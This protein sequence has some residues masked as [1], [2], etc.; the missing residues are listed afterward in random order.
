MRYAIVLSLSC[1]CTSGPSPFSRVTPQV[2]IEA[3]PGGLADE[4]Y[5]TVTLT[6]WN[7]L[8]VLGDAVAAGE[9][10]ATL[11]DAPLAL[12]PGTTGYVGGHDAYTVTFAL[13]APR[14]ASTA[15][16]AASSRIAIS[17]GEITWAAAVPNLFANDLAATAPLAAGSNTFVW[18]S[19]AATGP[20][21]TIEWACVAVGDQAS[22]CGGD[23]VDAQALAVSQQFITAT[24]AGSAGTPIAV[25]AERS[26][27]PD[28]SND[29]PTFFTHVFDRLD[30]RL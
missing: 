2:E 4:G 20:S 22:A 12:D 23:E 7:Q 9:L 16:S 11:D 19:A 13:A 30:A 1:A 21:S 25:T 8:D 14:S 28:S 26:A 29:G 18:P 17:D 15:P 3:N 6:T 27:D 10:S 24:V 5:F